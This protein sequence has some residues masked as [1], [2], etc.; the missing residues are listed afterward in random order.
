MPKWDNS[1][2]DKIKEFFKQKRKKPFLFSKKQWILFLVLLLVLPIMAGIATWFYQHEKNKQIKEKMAQE[3]ALYGDTSGLFLE[4]GR[5]LVPHEMK[6]E[7]ERQASL[8][9][10]QREL[11]NSQQI[12][13]KSGEGE[14]SDPAE[15]SRDIFI[16]KNDLFIQGLFSEIE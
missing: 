13:G 1:I 9:R 8:Y 7:R 16:E 2:L 10:T 5:I 14:W 4:K 15:I 3:A 12:L 11:W 6:G